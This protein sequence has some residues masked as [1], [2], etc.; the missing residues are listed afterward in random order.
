MACYGISK[1]QGMYCLAME[2]MNLNDM[3]SLFPHTK[4]KHY[5]EKISIISS[6]ALSIARG[7][8]HFH[9]KNIVHRDLRP[10]NILVKIK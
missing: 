4:W 3:G 5:D 9:S 10:E 6:I 7:I 8:K 1:I 2:Y